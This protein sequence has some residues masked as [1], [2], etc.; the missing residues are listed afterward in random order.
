MGFVDRVAKAIGGIVVKDGT[1]PGVVGPRVIQT[2]VSRT[3]TEGESGSVIVCTAA[4]L[5]ITLPAAIP[6]LNYTVVTGVLSAGV[7]TQ[8]IAS[9]G[10][11][12]GG[13]TTTAT[14]SGSADVLGDAI[15]VTATAAGDW[16]TTSSR[17]Q[18][19]VS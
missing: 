7:G 4:D 9:A 8:V 17:G 1:I 18:W 3:M 2:A 15:T 6:G 11:I 10:T 13:A 19:V 5:D 12:N 14:N 16:W